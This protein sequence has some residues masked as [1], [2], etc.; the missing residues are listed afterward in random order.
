[1]KI[2][3]VLNHFL[4]DNVAGTEVYVKSLSTHLLQN[5]HECIVIIP[6]YGKS[7]NDGYQYDNIKVIKFAEDS[8]VDRDLIMGFKLPNGIGSFKECLL[9]EKPDVVHFHEIAGSN[10]ITIN[11]VVEAKRLGFKTMFTFH[12]ASNSCKTGELLYKGKQLCD[13]IINIKKCTSCYLHK[14]QQP[15]ILSLVSAFLFLIGLDT[16]KWKSKVGT[17]LGTA[18]LIKQQQEKLKLLTSNCD[19]LVVLTNWYKSILTENGI[20]ENK[21]TYI[22]QALPNPEGIV[23]GAVSD[24]AAN[25]VLRLIFVGRISHFKGVHLLIDALLKLPAEKVS[26]SI[27]GQTDS[28]AYEEEL[29]NKTKYSSNIKWCGQLEQQNVVDTMKDFDVLCLCSTF[30]EMSPLVIQE[31]FEAKIPVVASHVYGN[32]EQIIDKENGWLFDFNDSE[33]L[34][35]ILQKL[36]GEPSLID[37]A[38]ANIKPVKKFSTVASEYVNL[39]TQILQEV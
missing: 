9:T 25:K 39:Y 16:T 2:I 32:A 34:K 6:N 12:L 33:C 30:S 24:K 36:V 15:K 29:R 5:G 8:E 21:I 17:A 27:F 10:G 18:F 31:A 19:Q 14:K 11:H 1:V 7:E 35:T 23:S 38:K 28:I 22:A 13:G 3:Q 26:L 4:P 20:P 37:I